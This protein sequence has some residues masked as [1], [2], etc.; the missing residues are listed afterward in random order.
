MRP[1]A[2]ITSNIAPPT[3]AKH[4]GPATDWALV[5]G[6]LEAARASP[7]EAQQRAPALRARILRERAQ[8]L[9]RE[10]RAPVSEAER[11]EVVEFVLGSEHYGIE[12]DAIREVFALKELTWL[13]AAPDFVLGIVN[14]RGQVLP[15]MDLRR[16]FDLPE[17]G[18]SDLN[19]VIV[20][21]YGETQAG[22]L[23]DCIVGLRSVLVSDLQP[24]LPTLNG[25]RAEYL[26]GVSSDRLVVLEIRKVL[27]DPN[28]MGM[29]AS[30]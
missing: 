19:K 1:E 24:S 29:P 20:V 27:S 4:A 6:R 26:R 25:V 18:L 8:Q 21:E 9:A 13:P 28:L 16:I 23:A 7:E 12:S 11:L 22:M 10:Q 30:G 5:R 2:P 15:V 14:V 17:K 3:S